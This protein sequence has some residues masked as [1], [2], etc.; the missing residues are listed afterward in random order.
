[1][2]SEPPS[3]PCPPR[4]A[5]RSLKLYRMPSKTSAQFRTRD[6]SMVAFSL[7]LLYRR[8]GGGGGQLDVTV[9]S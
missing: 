1:M 6:C 4:L 7:C 2:P 8:G 5:F 9:F 3:L